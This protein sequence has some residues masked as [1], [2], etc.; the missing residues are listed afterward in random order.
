MMKKSH[1]EGYYDIA[2]GVIQ[3][4]TDLKHLDIILYYIEYQ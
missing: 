2:I 1:V 3:P 4:P